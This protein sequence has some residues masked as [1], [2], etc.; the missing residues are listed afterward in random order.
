MRQSIGGESAKVYKL[1]PLEK[2]LAVVTAALLI[3]QPWAVGGMYLWTQY[4]AGGLALLAF[5]IALIP[6][7]Y[8][9]EH[10]PGREMK[11]IMWPK[12]LRFPFFWLG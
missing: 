10:H 11:L 5:I 4:V 9:E 3:F 12:L 1:H 2:A 8:T 6:R 7:H